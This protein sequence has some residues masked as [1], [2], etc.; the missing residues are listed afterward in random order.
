MDR[1]MR[2]SWEASGKQTLAQ[3]VRAKVLA[4]LGHHE[5]MPIP[6]EVEG[7]LKEIVTQADSR[8]RV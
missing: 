6:V 2:R 3:R 5:P 1:Q 4:I 8:H 7:R